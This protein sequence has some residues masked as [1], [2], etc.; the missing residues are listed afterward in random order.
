MYRIVYHR[1]ILP[2]AHNATPVISPANPAGLAPST[3][4]KLFPS[5][6]PDQPLKSPARI[7]RCKH[8][9]VIH[10]DATVPQFKQC[11]IQSFIPES[12]HNDNTLS[13]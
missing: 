4:H 5:K 1:F 11:L 3:H 9:F 6:Y 10:I 8:R 13:I 12:A 7:G 2:T